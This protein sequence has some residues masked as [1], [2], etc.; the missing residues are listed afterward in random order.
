MIKKIA[1]SALVIATS[2]F[3]KTEIIDNLNDTAHINL[4]NSDV[5]RLVFPYDITFQANSKEKDLTITVVGKEMYVKFMPYVEQE[6]TTIKNEVVNSGE[7]KIKYNK[8]KASELFVV[9][10]NKTYSLIVH[11]KKQEATTV[12]FTETF[13]EKKEKIF[14]NKDAEYVDNIVNNLFKQAFLKSDIKGF[15]KEKAPEAKSQIIALKEIR[16]DVVLKHDVVYS[17][18]RYDV[19]EYSIFNPDAQAINIPDTKE[20]LLS[21]APKL[22]KKILAYSLFYGNRVYKIMPNSKARLLIVT[23]AAHD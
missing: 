3:A 22:K 4:S 20:I 15:E 10:E 14:V 9:T 7:P 6:Q 21:I 19:Y 11:P 13:S 16:G 1:I 8:S 17:G 5:N 23:E 2:L 12:F 18:Y